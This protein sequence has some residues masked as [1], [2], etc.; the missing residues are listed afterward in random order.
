VSLQSSKN[1]FNRQG[2]YLIKLPFTH[3]VATSTTPAG[4]SSFLHLCISLQPNNLIA[5]LVT[6]SFMS[7]ILIPLL[8]LSAP[9]FALISLEMD[10][11]FVLSSKYYSGFSPSMGSVGAAF[12]FSSPSQISG[13]NAQNQKM[14][15]GFS[16]CGFKISKVLSRKKQ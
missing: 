8:P 7:F 13:L 15:F 11:S 1:D 9:Y 12:V 4:T 10:F 6:I 14:V 2:A 3:C 16:V 5:N